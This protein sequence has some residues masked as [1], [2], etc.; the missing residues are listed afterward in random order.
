[1]AEAIFKRDQAAQIGNPAQFKIFDDMVKSHELADQMSEAAKGTGGGS[2][3][4]YTSPITGEKTHTM[5]RKTEGGLL[6]LNTG[7]MLPD[8]PTARP[9]TKEEQLIWNDFATDSKEIAAF[10][11]KQADLAMGYNLTDEMLQIVQANPHVLTIQGS[12]TSGLTGISRQV[13]GVIDAIT[14][15]GSSPESV[16][17]AKNLEKQITDKLLSKDFRDAAEARELLDSKLKLAGYRFGKIEGQ[18]GRDLTQFDVG[19]LTDI[20][21]RSTDKDIFAKNLAGYMGDLRTGIDQQGA[22][23]NQYNPKIIALNAQYGYSPIQEVVPSFD[24]FWKSTSTS[25][26]Y[27]N[28]KKFEGGAKGKEGTSN[29]GKEAPTPPPGT[30]R[31]GR[32]GVN[33]EFLGGTWNDQNNW[34]RID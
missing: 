26:A 1:M 9:V 32:D 7:E 30:T 10:K 24:D 28:V 14:K 12:I 11:Q 6:D 34:K 29:K 21:A 19:R 22:Q 5:A 27:E 13:D 4:I 23:F 2:L 25:P 3:Y 15:T 20:I 17:T 18:E 33:W 8:D 16:Q 31:K